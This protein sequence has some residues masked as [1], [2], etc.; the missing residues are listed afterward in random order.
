MYKLKQKARDHIRF[1]GHIVGVS[2]KAREALTYWSVIVQ[3]K[4][5][6]SADQNARYIEN[7]AMKECNH[8]FKILNLLKFIFL[9]R[10]DLKTKPQQGTRQQYM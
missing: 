3:I 5:D 2:K 9:A 8:S 10:V 1:S 7:F 6:V 4:R